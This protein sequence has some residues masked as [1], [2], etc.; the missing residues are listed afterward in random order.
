LA[1]Y[2]IAYHG[3]K[4][5]PSEKEMEDRLTMLNAAF[6]A[7]PFVEE[8]IAGRYCGNPKDGFHDAACVKFKD[9]EAYRTHMR[10]P[11]GPDEATY[12][13][14]NIARIRAFDIITPDEPSDT[15]AKIIE[16]YKERWDQFPDVAKVLREEVDA[17]LPYL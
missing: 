14:E 4:R 15:E 1:I 11:H 9:I 8:G 7:A 6:A 12:L 3:Y 17:S 10:S 5:A 2:H 16:L 13:R